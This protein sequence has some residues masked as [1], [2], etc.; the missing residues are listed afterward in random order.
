MSYDDW[1]L[2]TPEEEGENECGYCGEPC[3]KEFCSRECKKAYEN[4]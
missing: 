1:K 3:E 4:D 2:A